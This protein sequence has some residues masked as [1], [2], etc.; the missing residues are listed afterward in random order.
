[1]PTQAAVEEAMA[2]SSDSRKAAWGD[3]MARR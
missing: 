2:A 1:L 3:V